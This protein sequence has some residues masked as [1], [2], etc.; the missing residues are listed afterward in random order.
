VNYTNAGGCQAAQPTVYTVFVGTPPGAAGPITGTATVCAGTNG[1][2]YSTSLVSGATS[3]TW[4]LPAGATIATGAGTNTITV[5]FGPSATSGVISVAGT[6]QCGNGT[7]STFNITVNPLPAAAGTI[8]GAAQV[9]TGNT[10]VYTVPAISGA[11]GYTWSVPAGATIVSGGNTNTATIAFG[12]SAGSGVITVLGTNTCGNGAVSPNFNVTINLTPAAPVVTANG[13]VLSS[14]AASGNQW[15][16]EGTGLISGA[17]GQNYTATITGWYWCTVTVNGCTSDTSNH[18]YVLFVGQEELS[19]SS[20]NVYPIPNNGNF[21]ASIH[22][23]TK[24]NFTIRVY[25]SLGVMMFEKNNVYV[26][27]D[28]THEEMI[29]LGNVTDGLY[30]VLF[31]NNKHKVAK[32][33]IVNKMV[34]K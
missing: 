20:F 29:N 31:I 9:C 10:Y 33:M 12:T 22:T 8:S 16:Y 2:T 14:S 23:P 4:I 5:N 21:I 15:Y 27:S 13:A 26:P 30:T 7:A 17:T 19:E 3:Y 18:V 6:N 1:V 32:K 24:D 11:T 34:T 28:G 25:N